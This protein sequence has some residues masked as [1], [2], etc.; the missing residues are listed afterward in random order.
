MK[1]GIICTKTLFTNKMFIKKTIF[2]NNIFTRRIT[3]FLF[4]HGDT[5]QV[6]FILDI[7]LKRNWQSLLTQ[8]GEIPLSYQ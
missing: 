2:T 1:V 8:T 5:S 6:T 3:T 4:T 7:D